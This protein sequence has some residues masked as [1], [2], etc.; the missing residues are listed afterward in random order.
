MLPALNLIDSFPHIREVLNDRPSCRERRILPPLHIAGVMTRHIVGNTGNRPLHI[1][2]RLIQQGDAETLQLCRH[3]LAQHRESLLRM[4]RDKDSFPLREKVPHQIC[5]GMRLARARRSLHNHGIMLRDLPGDG[6]L[7][8]VGG[9]GEQDLGVLPAK[10]GK[11]LLRRLCRTFLQHAFLMQS[12]NRPKRL[13]HIPRRINM[14][15][16]AVDKFLQSIHASAHEKN[17]SFLQ[18]Q[19]LLAVGRNLLSRLHKHTRRRKMMH[20]NPQK[21]AAL[22]SVKRVI[23]PFFERSLHICNGVVVH[24][25]QRTQDRRIK[26][27]IRIGI[28]DGNLVF[29]FVKANARAPQQDWMLY[30]RVL[31]IG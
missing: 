17:R 21:C 3:F 27:R 28:T 30:A 16:Y 24:I 4:A 20:G 9:H 23:I 29:L 19:A 7:L 18:K 10:L 14:L 12:R 6:E 5:N 2:V 22:R 31:C 26:L 13:R 1:A 25:L 8:T 15:K 11:P